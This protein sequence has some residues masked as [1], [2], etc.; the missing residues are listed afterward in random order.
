[1]LE[2]LIGMLVG[3]SIPFVAYALAVAVEIYGGVKRR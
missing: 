3:A 2:F 1:M